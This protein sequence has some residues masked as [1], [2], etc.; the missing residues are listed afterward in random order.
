[1]TIAPPIVA[2]AE[3][4]YASGVYDPGYKSHTYDWR[5]DP[6]TADN[7]A[8]VVP[9]FEVSSANYALNR[10][11][12]TDAHLVS[13]I[14]YRN[15]QPIQHQPRVNKR[16]LSWIQS[17]GYELRINCLFIDIDNPDHADHTS[18]SIA[19]F[20]HRIRAHLPDYGFYFTSGGV[21]LVAALT[22]SV[23]PNTAE[24]ILETIF[25]RLE[26]LQFTP[27]RRCRDW[28]RLY[29]L[30]NVYRDDKRIHYRSPLVE[31]STLRP[32]TI[33]PTPIVIHHAKPRKDA[34]ARKVASFCDACAARLGGTYQ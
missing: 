7:T 10:E 11:F 30:P 6:G 5:N 31:L 33:P 9:A 26:S 18:T 27:D 22:S 28:T 13:Y 4:K 17:L 19:S 20:A 8:G 24:E 3:R 12:Q 29:R 25:T 32:Q 21:R 15:G 1:M 16:G 23:D 34:P 14:V 2:Y